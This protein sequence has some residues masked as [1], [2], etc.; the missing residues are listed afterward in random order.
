MKNIKKVLILIMSLLLL[1][2]VLALAEKATA[3]EEMR[4]IWVASVLNI[5]YPS[6]STT[7]PETLKKEAIEILD[8]AQKIGINAVFLQIRP[9]ADAFYP[10]KYFPWSKYLTGKQGLAPDN[11]FDPMAYWIEEAHKRDIEVHAWINPYRIT[12]K[13]K[14]D[15][16]HDWNSLSK[17]HPAKKN[18]SWVVEHTDGNLY[19]NPGLPEVRQLIIDS[20]LELIENYDVDGIHFDDYFYPG[21]KFDDAKTY[22]TYGK[23]F[24][25]IQDWRRENVNILLRTLYSEIKAEDES[26]SFGISPFGIWANKGSESLGSDTRGSESY[27]DHYADSRTWVK[28]GYLDYITPQIY[29]NIGYKIADYQKLLTWWSDLV[30]DTNVKLYVGHAAYRT[31]NSNV[32]SPWNGVAEIERQLKLNEKTPEVSGSIFYN[33]SAIMNKPALSNLIQNYYLGNNFVNE[34]KNKIIENKVTENTILPKEY[35]DSSKSL[36]IGRP[37]QDLRTNYKQYYLNGTSNPN[38]PLYLNGNLVESRSQQGYF[39]ILVKLQTGQNKFTL[40]QADSSCTRII[41]KNAPWS[42]TAISK[43][44]IKSS[45][46]FPQNSEYRMKGEKINLSC[47]APIGADVNVQLNGQNYKMIPNT[48]VN[49]GTKVY[50]TTYKYSYVVPSIEGTPR[51]INLGKPIYTMN[52]KGVQSIKTAPAEVGIIMKKAPY[53]AEISSTVAD[54]YRKPPS[55]NGS[56]FEVYKGMF[57]G[58]TAVSGDYVRL[59]NELWVKKKFVKLFETDA[60]KYNSITNTLY[61]VGKKE[62]IIKLQMTD[63]AM[64]IANFDGNSI[65]VDLVQTNAKVPLTLAANGLIGNISQENVNE[66]FRYTLRLKEGQRLGG[67]YVEKTST[68]VNI[69]LKKKVKASYTQRPLE[70]IRIMIDPGHGGKDS[71]A[72]GPFGTLYS[73]KHLNLDSAL[74]LQKKLQNMGAEIIMTRTTDVY[75]SLPER[76]ALSR[77]ARPDLFVSIHADSMAD[78]VDIS[79]ITGF[80]VYYHEVFA[81]EPA[82]EIL[83]RTTNNLNR[84]NRGMHNKLFYVVRGTWAPSILFE[85]GF[86]PNPE[87]FEWLINENEQDKFIQN[88]ADSLLSYFAN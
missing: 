78:N 32:E 67:Y 53:Y 40:T 36:N 15:L 41:T 69:H 37:T 18:P 23:D 86:I 59:D 42:P 68:G 30:R 76:L 57:E 79:K 25:N 17:N 54:L 85:S 88:I 83:S 56:S 14:N 48:T 16:A 10:S 51:K 28:S 80:S 29:W 64:T 33:T 75:L 19:F 84:K 3:D 6:K 13:T 63:S 38:L 7:N 21:R 5:D 39:G 66:D 26:V 82:T 74:K 24:A 34:T 35:Y 44:E 72:L 70:G 60:V 27:N 52:Y 50:A 58:V 1:Q 43:F 2:P 61:E 87:E 31:E 9:T 73:E 4:G 22:E 77:A 81:K 65:V 62:D 45:S 49:N 8:N 71:G 20:V 47:L 46:T 55:S 11:Y 12:K